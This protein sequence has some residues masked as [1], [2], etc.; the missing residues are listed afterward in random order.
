MLWERKNEETWRFLMQ[1]VNESGFSSMPETS[2]SS[3]QSTSGRRKA[4]AKMRPGRK[5]MDG[6]PENASEASG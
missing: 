4:S 3:G 2:L 6:D 1:L 5:M